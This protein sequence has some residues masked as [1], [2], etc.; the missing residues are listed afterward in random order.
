MKPLNTWSPLSNVTVSLKSSKD[1]QKLLFLLYGVAVVALLQSNFYVLFS[2]AL[3]AVLSIYFVFLWRLQT[4]GAPCVRLQY[5]EQKWRVYPIDKHFEVCDSVRIR[6]DFGW[7]MWLVLQSQAGPKHVLLFRD[8]LTPD[9][10]RLLR[11]LLR[12]CGT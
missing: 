3:I 9:E 7:L 4:P 11:V 5:I 6:F 12:V 8:Q 10:N 2:V 1:Y